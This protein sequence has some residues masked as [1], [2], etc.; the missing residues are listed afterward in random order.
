M[1]SAHLVPIFGTYFDQITA[2]AIAGMCFGLDLA[3]LQRCEFVI[4]EE[5]T[6]ATAAAVG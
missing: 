4:L 5:F 2:V 6:A 1:R 3:I